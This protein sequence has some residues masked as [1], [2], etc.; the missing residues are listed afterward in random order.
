MCAGCCQ[1]EGCFKGDSLKVCGAN[2]STCIDC[3]TSTVVGPC[4]KRVCAF[5]GCVTQDKP[6]GTTCTGTGG[7]AG[8]CVKGSCCV[9]CVHAGT[10]MVSGPSTCGVGGSA[11][12]DCKKAASP[13]EEPICSKG[14]CATK[15]LTIGAPCL[16]S[17]GAVGRCDATLACCN[18]CLQIG[19]NFCLPGTATGA[20]GSDGNICL[21]CTAPAGKPC[22]A[23]ACLG[24]SCG[25]VPRAPHTLCQ[26]SF[27]WGGNLPGRC[28]AS[29]VCCEGCLDNGTCRI[30]D[31][32]RCGRDG[33][34]CLPCGNGQACV[35]GQCVSP[36]GCSNCANGC[37]SAG[38]CVPYAQQS[39]WACGS[40]S[41]A[42]VACGSGR[43]C[44]DGHCKPGVCNATTCA[45]GC[46]TPNGSCMTTGHQQDDSCGTGGI[47]CTNCKAGSK[48]CKNGACA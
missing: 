14:S 19:T 2:G 22:Q 43:F 32:N 17:T 21:G 31:A 33:K 23:A 27:P 35:T 44:K 46:C 16:T 3:E 6:D 24:G 36:G 8:T 13:C 38:L 7:K 11:C 5:G 45:D 9:G 28:D 42:C 39:L 48:V 20:C 29:G 25:H 10:C 12:A 34:P 1:G 40:G 4:H 37:C 41:F 47:N 15:P 18:G 30:D 26:L